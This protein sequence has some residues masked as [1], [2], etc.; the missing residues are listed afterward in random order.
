MGRGG[1]FIRVHGC[2]IEVLCWEGQLEFPMTVFEGGLYPS[3]LIG[4]DMGPFKGGYIH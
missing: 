4:W 1:E 2:P 3:R